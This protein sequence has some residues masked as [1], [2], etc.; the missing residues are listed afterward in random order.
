MITDMGYCDGFKCNKKQQCNRFIDDDLSDM[1][2]SKNQP[3]TDNCDQFID[4]ELLRKEA[5][6][7]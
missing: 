3:D 5:F 7:D 2:A 1:T 4:M 6:N